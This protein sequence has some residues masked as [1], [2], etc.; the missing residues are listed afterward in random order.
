MIKVII[1]K[2]SKIVKEFNASEQ[3]LQNV[4][5]KAVNLAGGMWNG[6]D[7]FSVKISK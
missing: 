6:K 3:T 1:L 2:N 5:S 4:F 7:K